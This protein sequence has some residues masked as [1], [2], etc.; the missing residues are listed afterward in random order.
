MGIP[1]EPGHCR[2]EDALCGSRFAGAQVVGIPKEFA[3]IATP[4]RWLG[5]VPRTVC[6]WNQDRERGQRLRGLGRR[7]YGRARKSWATHD[8]HWSNP[9][10]SAATLRVSVVPPSGSSA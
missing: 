6:R 10:R 8:R 7:L 3:A 2:K 4:R 9:D 5:I 1:R